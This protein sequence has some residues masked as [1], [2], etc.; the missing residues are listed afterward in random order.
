MVN[1]FILSEK[2]KSRIS[3][4]HTQKI[5]LE[6]K[7]KNSNRNITE[8][9]QAVQYYKDQTGKVI[10]LVG[11]QSPPQGATPATPGEYLDQNP[12][13]TVS[14][15]QVQPTQQTLK[16]RWD[17]AQCPTGKGSCEVK[18]LVAQIKINEFCT[19]DV[20]NAV[21]TNLPKGRV[22]SAG[23]YKLKED[24]IWGN[25]SNSV[26]GA[27]QKSVTENINKQKGLTPQQS[28]S[29]QSGSQSGPQPIPVGGNLT[30]NDIKELI[31]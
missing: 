11:N 3:N 19:P 28:G 14:Q 9:E 23:S 24:G 21:L 30:A 10:K 29:Q 17:T 7:F 12:T 16:G 27:C 5:L 18:S 2:E 4:L 6:R 20:L 15:T 25:T 31:S 13:A 22:G 26:W 1:K 8:Q